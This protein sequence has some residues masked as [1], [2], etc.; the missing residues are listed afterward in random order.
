MSKKKEVFKGFGTEIFKFLID[1][2]KNNNVDWFH[3][4]KDRYQETLV[5]PA[6]LFVT[7]LA[8]FFNRIN[9]SIRTEPK[10]NQTL[11]RLNR[12]MRFAKGAP[13]KNYFLIHFGR[14]KMDSEYFLYFD[15]NSTDLGIFLNKS[16]GENLYFNQNY[17]R[18]KKE[19]V[20]VFKENKLNNKFS[21][22]HMDSKEPTEVLKRFNAEKHIDKLEDYNYILFQ[23]NTFDKKK[24][25]TDSLLP[26]TVKVFTSLYPL[27]CFAYFPDP[28]KEITKFNDTFGVI[29]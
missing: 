17:K 22:F 26:F 4:N 6:R 3:K 27:L 19:I 16:G 28:L 21:L 5:K 8:S 2:E 12:D 15:P 7:E 18:Y 23:L 1:L 24:V 14:F 11:M 13:Y 25:A 29:E 9:P 20:K 10:F